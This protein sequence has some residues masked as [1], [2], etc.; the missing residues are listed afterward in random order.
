M[1]MMEQ[2]HSGG[3]NSK[4]RDFPGEDRLETSIVYLDCDPKRAGEL[5]P[6]GDVVIDVPW[7]SHIVFVDLEPWAN[8]EHACSYLTIRLNGYDVIEFVAQMPPFLKAESSSFS[9]L[10]HG[11]L[12]P[13]W[14]MAGNPCEE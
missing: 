7:D 10:W 14:A 1:V 8:W 9:L 13:E 6:V 4:V 12:A 3:F 11:P 5:V 2:C